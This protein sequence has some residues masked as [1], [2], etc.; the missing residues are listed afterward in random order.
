[1]GTTGRKDFT[2]KGKY[3]TKLWSSRKGQKSR[4]CCEASNKL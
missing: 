1:M 4:T 3:R 2:Q